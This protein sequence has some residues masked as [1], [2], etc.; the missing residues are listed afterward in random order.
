M[1]KYAGKCKRTHTQQQPYILYNHKSL[2]SGVTQEIWWETVQSAF[3][4]WILVLG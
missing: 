2:T 4:L 1:F 3:F